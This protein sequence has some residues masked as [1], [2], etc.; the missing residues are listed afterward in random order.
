MASAGIASAAQARKSPGGASHATRPSTSAITR[1]AAGRQR[2]SRC[3]ATTTAVPQSSF[4]RRSSQTSS[5]PATGSSCDVGSSSS[6]SSRTVDHRRRERHALQLAAGERV[7]AALEQVGDAERQ[8]RLL[9]RARQRRRR[10]AAVLER[11]L[12]LG[13]HAAHHHLRLGLLEHRAAHGGQLAR[14]VLAHVEP[15]D[16]ELAARL[17]A[18][19]VRDEP[20]ERAQQRRLARAGQAGQHG[21]RAGLDLERDVVERAARRRRGSE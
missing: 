20:A 21:E 11:Q 15:A 8:R 7:G 10:L 1:S 12:E 5:S 14:A 13:P 6:S 18:V 3:S 9:H 2:S 19:E 16:L 17:A 4:S